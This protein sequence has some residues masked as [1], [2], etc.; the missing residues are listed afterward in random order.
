MSR[1]TSTSRCTATSFCLTCRIC[2][3]ILPVNRMEDG[4]IAEKKV[5]VG[6]NVKYEQLDIYLT[7]L[8]NEV[9]AK[10]AAKVQ[11][12]L[13][14]LEAQVIQIASCSSIALYHGK[15]ACLFEDARLTV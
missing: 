11:E 6:H 12:E 5:D 10:E 15:C 1:L 9:R 3:S 14:A 8:A 13:D 7:T 4:S 2:V